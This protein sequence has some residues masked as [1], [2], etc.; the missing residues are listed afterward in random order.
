M[1]K[2]LR[3]VSFTVDP[4]SGDRTIHDIVEIRENQVFTPGDRF[5]SAFLGHLKRL[6]EDE[7]WVQQIVIERGER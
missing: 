3:L 2:F 5:S 1:T 7:T 4:E 6:V